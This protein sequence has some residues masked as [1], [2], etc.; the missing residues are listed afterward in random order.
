MF[1]MEF[2]DLLLR[3]AFDQLIDLPQTGHRRQ[4][5]T[6]NIPDGCG[7]ASLEGHHHDKAE[8]QEGQC[9]VQRGLGPMQ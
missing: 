8:K 6:G 2:H 9:D 3:V 1:A 5:W 4:P 7:I